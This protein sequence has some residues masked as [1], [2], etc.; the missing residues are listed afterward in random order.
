[1]ARRL[2]NRHPNYL[3]RTIH[4]SWCT[5][6][7]MVA[8]SLDHFP[9][10]TLTMKGLLLPCCRECNVLAG[11]KSGWDFD[12]RCAIVKN[13]LRRRYQKAVKTPIW[14]A[15]E[16]SEMGRLMK[17]EIEV[18]QERRRL[19]HARLAWNA[20]SYLSSIDKHNAFADFHAECGFT[21]ECEPTPIEEVSTDQSNAMLPDE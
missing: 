11:T 8:D 1:M 5:Y 9:P 10:A 21:T 3:R 20:A 16:I 17:G 14:T 4:G 6:C 18:W 15:D 12:T 7:G 2:T 19:I 13:K